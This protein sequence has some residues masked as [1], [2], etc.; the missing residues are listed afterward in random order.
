MFCSVEEICNKDVINIE[1]G[2]RVGYVLDVEIDIC[3][4]RVCSL[5]VVKNEKAVSLRRPESIKICWSDIAVM[6]S[7]TILVKN[8]PQIQ[9]PP[10]V[11]KRFSD[12]FSK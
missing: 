2:N 5:I 9:S 6:G 10:K 1:N 4:G 8:V 3:S 7:E 11:N 12:I